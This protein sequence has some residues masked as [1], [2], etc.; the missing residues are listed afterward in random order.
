MLKSEST[1]ELKIEPFLWLSTIYWWFISSLG[2]I[3]RQSSL[4]FQGDNQLKGKDIRKIQCLASMLFE[5]QS[6]KLSLKQA[7]PT[8]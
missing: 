7:C 5:K 8:S 3:L 4:M 6:G 1:R 2:K